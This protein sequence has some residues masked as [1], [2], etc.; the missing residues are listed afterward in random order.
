MITLNKNTDKLKIIE[1]QIGSTT[2]KNNIQ[3]GK[4]N[5]NGNLYDDC[6]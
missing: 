4:V 3:N 6:F 2:H 1:Q 5:V